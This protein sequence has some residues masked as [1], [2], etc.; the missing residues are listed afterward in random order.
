MNSKKRWS[1][2]IVLA[3]VAVFTAGCEIPTLMEAP[4]MATTQ[5]GFR[6]T[7][8]VEIYNPE[9]LAAQAKI[10]EPAAV[11]AFPAG[12]PPASSQFK[13]LKVLGNL[14]VSE[15]TGLMLALT[16]WVSPEQG[17]NY[18]H[19]EGDMASDNV[20]TKVVARRM[21]QM[22]QE[23]NQNWKS[24]V[25]A[26]GV[27]CYTCHRGQPVPP[28]VW[29][30][31]PGPKTALGH[32]G[33]RNGQNAPEM[34]VGLTSLPYDPMTKFLK[35]TNDLRVMPRTALPSGDNPKSLVQTEETYAQMVYMS[36]SLGV[37]CTYCHNTQAFMDWT[38]SPPQRVT[39]WHGIN[40]TKEL[41]NSFLEPLQPVF[42]ANRLGPL[43]DAPKVGCATCHQNAYKP[44]YGTPA[45]KDFPVL[46]SKKQ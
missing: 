39:A 8:M 14:N 26:T 43:G 30:T 35:N 23:I 25:A 9:T 38:L 29:F 18:C 12:G 11:V 37:N 3:A 42:P 20:Y 16:A 28:N 7:A 32:L 10:N 34:N 15:F 40:L 21:L 45:V 4:P 24:H 6:G 13:N 17:C 2:S 1:W 44:L 36:K 19:V 22:T 31:N 46:A 33:W 27:N 5:R 41:N